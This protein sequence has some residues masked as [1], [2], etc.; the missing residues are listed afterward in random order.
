MKAIL[1]NM[2][3]VLQI[4]G[5]F[6]IIPIILSFVFGET[7]ASLALFI[8]STLFFALGFVLNSLSERKALSFKQSC[9]L[10]ILVFI[11]LSL[12]GAIPY[13][14]FISDGNLVKALTDSIFESVSGYTTTGFSVISD[15]TVLPRSILFYRALTQFIGGI[16]IVLLLLAFFFP[17]DKLKQFSRSMGFPENHKIKKTFF[18]ILFIYSVYCIGMFV[19]GFLLGYRDIIS[20]VSFIF[21][22]IATGG[23]S[24]VNDI[25]NIVSA[26][27]LGYILVASMALGSLNF[28]VLAGLF[29][30]RIKEFFKSE[31]TLFIVLSVFSVLVV[32]YMFG[33]GIFDS[34]FHVVS[35]SSTTGFSYLP[36]KD[37][38]TNLKLFL[39]LLMFV[40]GTSLSTA[41][42]IKIY[43]LAL[44]YKAVKKAVVESITE[45]SISVKLFGKEYDDKEIINSLV[46]IV[47]MVILIFVSTGL[48]TTYGFSFEDSI[49]DV[50][51]AVATTGLSSGIVGPSLAMNF[52]WMFMALMILGRVEVI[53]FFIIMSSAKPVRSF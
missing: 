21:S 22:A 34:M 5:I 30:L 24:P 28:I 51:S 16:G 23:F 32:K 48:L 46:V 27:P 15:L 38:H 35:A 26:S 17:E 52:K 2:G 3:F 45:R 36:I 6:I 43:R 29:K 47:L 4:T 1:S 49:F 40:G 14:H 33:F 42:G 19:L 18:L 12:I 11:M 13:I 50:T 8:T 31:I 10:I 41:G 20:L 53:A 44:I 39:T 7:M 25:T 9:G 37:F